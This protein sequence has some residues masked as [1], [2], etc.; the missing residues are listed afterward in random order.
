VNKGGFGVWPDGKRSA[1][2]FR[3]IHDLGGLCVLTNHPQIIGRPGRLPLL[4]EFV[5]LV[6]ST[7]DVWVATAREVAER[8]LADASKHKRD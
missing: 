1:A 4:E 6:Q 7:D 5:K 8:V 2:T 3:G